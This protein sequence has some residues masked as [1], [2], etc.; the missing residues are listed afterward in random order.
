VLSVDAVARF[1]SVKAA[2]GKLAAVT[3]VVFVILGLCAHSTLK[4]WKSGSAVD[5]AQYAEK[6][7]KIIEQDRGVILTDIDFHWLLFFYMDTPVESAPVNR[8]NFRILRQLPTRGYIF[9]RNEDTANKRFKEMLQKEIGTRNKKH[10]GLFNLTYL[11]N[12]QNVR[13]TE[14]PSPI[15]PPAITDIEKSSDVIRVWFSHPNPDKVSHFLVYRKEAKEVFYLRRIRVAAGETYAEIPNDR[16]AG[17]S[18][19]VTA[20]DKH[21]EESDFSLEIKG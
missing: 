11:M 5:Y 4:L 1:V 10:V 17:V 6:M 21:G 2:A 12:T 3:L 14:F 8:A 19:I 9:T 7:N 15:E 20:V 13:E 18:V 16:K